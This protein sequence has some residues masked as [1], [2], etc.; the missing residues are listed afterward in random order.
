MA[1]DD[2]W[3]PIETAPL[4]EDIALQVTDG[5]RNPYILQWP[6]RLTATGWINSKKGNPLEV[7]PVRW[8]PFPIPL[9]PPR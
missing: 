3:N 1:R 7:T 5:R 2:G 4:D 9:R 8:R 6:C